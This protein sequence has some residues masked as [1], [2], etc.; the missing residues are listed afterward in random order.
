M[1]SGTGARTAHNTLYTSTRKSPRNHFPGSVSNV[2]RRKKTKPVNVKSLKEQ[3]LVLSYEGRFRNLAI[4][5]SML[6]V[7]KD[8][9]ARFSMEVTAVFVSCEGYS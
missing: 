8:W 4:A 3:Y 9:I 5:C 1:T 2:R 6:Q 7:E